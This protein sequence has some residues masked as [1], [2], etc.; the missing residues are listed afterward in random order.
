M[1][2]DLT[3][4]EPSQTYTHTQEK[5]RDENKYMVILYNHTKV[6]DGNYQTVI[7]H[8]VHSAKGPCGQMILKSDTSQSS[9]VEIQYT[10]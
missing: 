10:H 1:I 5:S 3:V 4:W 2:M 9:F 7:S 6:H 8:N